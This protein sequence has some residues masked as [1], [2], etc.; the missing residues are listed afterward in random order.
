M[1]EEG[2]G[3]EKNIGQA[4]RWY[5]KAAMRGLP[6]AENRLGHIYYHGSGNAGKDF[7]KAQ[8]WLTRAANHDV[9]EAQHTLGHMYQEGEGVVT[10]KETAADLLNKAAANGY[11]DAET[12]A[13]KVPPLKPVTKEGPL[14]REIEMGMGN[15]EQSWEGYGDIVQ[16]LRSLSAS[17]SANH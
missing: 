11:K 6:E 7:K 13:E 17:S 5:E 4:I 10:N 9:A 15:I 1:Y 8:K 12:I 2:L 14:G 16:T 3:V